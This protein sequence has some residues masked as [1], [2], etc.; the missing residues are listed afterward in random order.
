V[1]LKKCA[2]ETERLIV[3]EWHSPSAMGRRPLDLAKVLA[4]L[5]TQAVT[6]SLPAPWQGNYT[7]DRARDWIRE[8]DREGATLLVND[9]STHQIVG[10]MVLV[11]TPAE[12]V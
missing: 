12:P 7:L 10:L 2:F 11:E 9:K 4:S 1:L 6:R 8:R 3:E 5:L